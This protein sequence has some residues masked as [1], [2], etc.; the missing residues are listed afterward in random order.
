LDL[1]FERQ[2]PIPKIAIW[3][4]WTQPEL[5]KQ[6]FCPRPWSTTHCEIDLRPGGSFK[7]T[8]CSPEGVSH[9]NEGIYLEIVHAK[10]L[11]WTNALL[12]GFRPT[13]NVSIPGL[14]ENGFQFTAIIELSETQGHTHY[15][16]S[17][18]H[19]NTESREKHAS[20]GFETGWGIAL[21]QMIKMIQSNP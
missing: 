18:L 9:D 15:R 4:A 7:T 20:M 6:W 14:H 11:V 17:V 3:N 8:M 19:G 1:T 13:H 5:L 2:V 16:A 21:D 12:T 10:R